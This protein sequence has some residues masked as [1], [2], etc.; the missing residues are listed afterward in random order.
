MGR[1]QRGCIARW[2]GWVCVCGYC[3]L[4]RNR[5]LCL[6][7][8]PPTCP[9]Q[10]GGEPSLGLVGEAGPHLLQL[11]PRDAEH[12]GHESV[13]AGGQGRVAPVGR[14]HGAALRRAAALN[15]RTGGAAAA[16]VRVMLGLQRGG[17]EHGGRQ[18]SQRAVPRE[19]VPRESVLLQLKETK[20]VEG[21]EAS[22]TDSTAPSRGP[23]TAHSPCGAG[24][25]AGPEGCAHRPDRPS[26]SARAA[27]SLPAAPP[28]RR[29]SARAASLQRPRPLSSP[30]SLAA[31]ARPGPAGVSCGG[32]I[33]PSGRPFCS[34][35]RHPSP[36]LFSVLLTPCA[37][38]APTAAGGVARSRTGLWSPASP[39]RIA[40]L[41]T[42]VGPQA[43]D[44]TP[45][46]SASSPVR[47]GWRCFPLPKAV[48]TR[49]RR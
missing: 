23:P 10:E 7:P 14:P 28:P 48:V 18:S 3:V 9:L 43:S 45:R 2:A 17:G 21:K 8:A 15:E 5:G 27:S 31:R 25:P 36:Q 49:L 11:G 42:W 33:R 13:V 39:V 29:P 12:R 32:G 19:G 47:C 4:G 6:R 35:S 46:A 1:R 22:G 24:V 41:P 30:R 26:T 20:R 44:F 16:G 38:S 40:P 34:C 37:P